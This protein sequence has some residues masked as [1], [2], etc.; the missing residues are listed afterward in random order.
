M[1]PWL[2]ASALPAAGTAAPPA[3][4][5]WVL[6]R[7]VWGLTAQPMYC[8]SR[9][10]TS[11]KSESGTGGGQNG[12]CFLLVNCVDK[13]APNQSRSARVWS[14]DTSQAWPTDKRA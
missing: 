10:L 12:C 5:N 13:G 7:F 6:L 4:E 8:T 11:M 14:Q 3:P 9:L 1:S 2:R